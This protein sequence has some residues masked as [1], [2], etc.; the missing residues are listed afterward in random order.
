MYVDDDPRNLTVLEASLPDE[1]EIHTF[2][3]AADALNEIDKIKPWVI[4]SDQRMPEM[5][6]VEFLEIVRKID[7]NP[8]RIIVT[9]YSD[10]DLIVESVRKAQIFD[11][12][13]KPWDPDDLEL[14][15]Q[16]AFDHYKVVK[17]KNAYI[18]DIKKRDKELSAKNKELLAKAEELEVAKEHELQSRKELECW[19]HPNLL[20]ALN[21]TDITFPYT[22]DL[23]VV[24]FDIVNSSG[25]HGVSIQGKSIRSVIIQLFTECVVR[26]GGWRESHSGDSA[27]AH[28]GMFN[29][30]QTPAEAMVSA[31]QEFKV[32]LNNL[33]RMNKLDFGCGIAIHFAKNCE[34]AI[35]EVLLNTPKGTFIQKSFDTSSLDVDIVHKIEKYAHRLKGVNV[36]V[37]G[38]FVEQCSKTG[39]IIHDLGSINYPCREKPITL[40][41]VKDEDKVKELDIE[42]LR[43]YILDK[44]K[45]AA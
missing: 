20:E 4:L 1:W 28:F 37:S 27:F 7:P 25:L 42:V 11:Y 15:L 29:K 10:E 24:A 19:V 5:T 36:I 8:I 9:G 30:H 33:L 23:Y 3:K 32:S 45:R 43:S 18:E 31:V 26:N 34:I 21:D 41:L 16:H 44:S 13:R 38:D 35:H 14:S 2:S 12:I 39:L 22:Q 17:E 40:H 6:G